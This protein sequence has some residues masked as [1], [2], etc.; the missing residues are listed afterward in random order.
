MAYIK[1]IAY[2]YERQPSKRQ[3]KIRLSNG[4]TI[5]AES[6]CESWQQWGGTTDDLFITMP[7]VEEHNAWLHGGDRP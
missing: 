6:C 7:I 4:T 3:L 1:S 5:R 2:L